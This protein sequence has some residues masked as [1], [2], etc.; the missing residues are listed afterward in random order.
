MAI[1][2]YS[3]I[4]KILIIIIQAFQGQQNISVIF[5]YQI[6]IKAQKQKWDVHRLKNAKLSAFPQ[7]KILKFPLR[8]KAKKEMK[9]F[10]LNQEFLLMDCK[11]YVRRYNQP[12]ENSTILKRRISKAQ[13]ST[14]S[15]QTY[16]K[17]I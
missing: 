8:K 9:N 16:P 12:L 10:N 7:K 15:F 14:R 1:K 17:T 2:Y 3:Q 6:G 4:T 11:K 5:N 13:A